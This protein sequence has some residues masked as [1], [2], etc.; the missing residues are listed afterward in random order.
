MLAPFDAP[1]LVKAQL[2]TRLQETVTQLPLS[3]PGGY[4]SLTL[5]LPHLPVAA[6]DL[7]EP[8]FL[9]SHARREELRAGYGIAGQWQT[10]GPERLRRLRVEAHRLKRHWYQCDP[11]ETGLEGFVLVGFAAAPSASG[12]T[13]IDARAPG[14]PDALLWLP[15][16]ALHHRGGQAALVLTTSLPAEPQEVVG[17]WTAWL[18]RLVPRLCS[19]PLG[20]LTPAPV[21]RRWTGPD[22]DA[23]DLRVRAVLAAIAGGS[24]DKVVLARRLCVQGRRPFDLERLVA[25]LA[26]LFPSCQVAKLQRDGQCLV[27]ATPERLL[28]QRGSLVEVDAIAGTAARAAGRAP[29]AALGEA[30][31]TSPKELC[32]HALVTESLRAALAPH[33]RRLDVPDR[34]RLLHLNN[35]QHLW[36]PIRAE[37]APGLDA[38]AL[39]D[40]LHPTPATNGQPGDVA[41]A[42]LH[43][44]EPQGR[45]WY[46]GAAGCLDPDLSGEL[47]VLLRCAEIDGDTA[48]LHAGAGIVAG[49]DPESEWAETE[50]KLAA[51]LTA[52][53]FA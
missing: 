5:E 20:P 31:R 11:D 18:D 47:W 36:T 29:D 40:L 3:L 21:E 32:E 52:L 30:L 2:L 23:W 15:E 48:L 24:L 12:P 27:A 26:Y 6:P 17:R 25:A 14:L 49:S 19:G 44:V 43:Q 51:M 28:A 13:G 22:R 7:P 8:Q 50:H 33:S 9:F 53:Q 1:N 45:G 16:V 10:A 4:A 38:L 46:T 41:R 35:V 34:P 42:W 37:V 39:A